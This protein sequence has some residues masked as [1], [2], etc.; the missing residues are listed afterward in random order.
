MRFVFA[1]NRQRVLPAPSDLIPEF[2]HLARTRKGR[3]ILKDKSN[4]REFSTPITNLREAPITL[5]NTFAYL[6][7]M[8]KTDHRPRHAEI[9]A[10]AEKLYLESGSLPGRDE[11]NWLNAEAQLLQAKAKT[12]NEP[13]GVRQ[14]KG[15]QQTQKQ[16]PVSPPPAMAGAR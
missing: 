8:E 6:C 5:S 1:L 10:L 11:Q 2:R 13:I 12:N 9:A 7:P 4:F 15:K 14:P 3:I 16:S